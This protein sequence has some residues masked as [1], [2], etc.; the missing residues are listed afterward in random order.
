M[1]KSLFN[2]GAYPAKIDS[3]LLLIRI[4]VAVFMLTHGIGK[5]LKLLAN[6]PVTFSDPLDIGPTASLV[7]TVFSE[8]FCSLFLLFG[9]VTR[10]A[11][12]PLIITMLVIIFI[13]QIEKGF[14]KMELPLFFL[15]NF[16]V[17]LVAG[18]GRYSIDKLIHDKIIRP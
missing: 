3:L 14:D 10:L 7:L 12:I 18:P 9:F 15:L 6:E 8:V 1:L 17:V 16:I 4:A 2:P 11:V 13:V 5:L